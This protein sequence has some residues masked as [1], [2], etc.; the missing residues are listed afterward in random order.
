MADA[1]PAPAA[2]PEANPD[3]A[4][5]AELAARAAALV[6]AL[7]SGDSDAQITAADEVK[8]LVV[9]VEK[10]KQPANPRT[11]AA[12]VA[13]GVGA[14]LLPL[15]HC[16]SEVGTAAAYALHEIM[17]HCDAER[18]AVIDTL[19]VDKLLELLRESNGDRQLNLAVMLLQC[20]RCPEWLQSLSPDNDLVERTMSL[21]F[22]STANAQVKRMVLAFVLAL[23]K[24]HPSSWRAVVPS[25]VSLLV[26]FLSPRTDSDLDSRLLAAT[27]CELLQFLQTRDG[28]DFTIFDDGGIYVA[29]VEL[30]GDLCR[31]QV[32]YRKIP[33]AAVTRVL[34]R[35]SS[36]SLLLR[37]HIGRL[38]LSC[39][40]AFGSVAVGVYHICMNKAA[41]ASLAVAFIDALRRHA[42]AEWFLLD[43]SFAAAWIRFCIPEEDVGT[44]GDEYVILTEELDVLWDTPKCIHAVAHPLR[45]QRLAAAISLAS[46]VYFDSY[47]QLFASGDRVEIFVDALID[48]AAQQFPATASSVPDFLYWRD[49]ILRQCIDWLVS[50]LSIDAIHV[51]DDDVPAGPAAKR[52]RTTSAAALR[53]SDVNVQRRDSTVLLIAGRP[54]Y[55]FGALLET[56]SAVLADA[57]SSATTLDPVAI[58]LPNEVPEEQQYALFHAAVELAYTGTMTSSEVATESLLPLWCLGDHLQ[59]D[60]LCTWCV[61]RL[62]PALADNAALL[63]RAWTAALARPSD[64]LGD[65]C[66]TAWLLLEKRKPVGNRTAMNLLKRVH[67]GCAAKELVAAQLVRVLRKALLAPLT[68]DAEDSDE[69][70]SEDEE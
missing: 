30:L 60:E 9:A 24:Q 13:A 40:G 70:S 29:C 10:S 48:L 28:F 26:G 1:D 5:D 65:A 58:P 61:E 59:M 62:T 69:D 34:M 51:E 49:Q 67:D 41:D 52:A 2:P 22:L 39:P 18:R 32:D 57:L 6:A 38:V 53:A 64:A 68:S 36:E 45:H 56:K 4:S 8:L 21:P 16:V 12:L 35:A 37:Q 20:T 11:V 50:G 15:I 46:L 27:A 3:L 31:K 23:L 54:F 47:R 63:E 42:P 7:R 19:G 14:A 66:A 17:Y 43:P 44:A 55:V 25:R 33:Q